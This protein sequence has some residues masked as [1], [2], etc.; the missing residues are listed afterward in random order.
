MKSNYFIDLLF[1]FLVSSFL[2]LNIFSNPSLGWDGNFWIEKAIIFYEEGEFKDLNYT[3]FPFY[4]HLGGYIWSFF[5]KIV[6]Q[7]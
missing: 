1:I 4:P 7:L 2:A 5:W 6:F 3:I